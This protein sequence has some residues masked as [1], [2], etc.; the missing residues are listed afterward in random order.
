MNVDPQ[1][2]TAELP[3]QAPLQFQPPLS[4]SSLVRVDI[5]ARSDR[6]KLRPSNEDHFLV[7]RTGRHLEVL[8]TNLPAGEV[9]DTSEETVWHGRGGWHGW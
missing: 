3:K 8:A 7:A 9:P 1:A 5:A 6:G 2:A 4:F